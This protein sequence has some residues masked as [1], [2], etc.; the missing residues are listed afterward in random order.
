M[1]FSYKSGVTILVLS[2]LVLFIVMDWYVVHREDSLV[3]RNRRKEEEEWNIK[4]RQYEAE[5]ARHTSQL[6]QL[7]E[8]KANVEKIALQKQVLVTSLAAEVESKKKGIEKLDD[9]I[10]QL[11]KTKQTIQEQIWSSQTTLKNNNEQISTLAQRLKSLQVETQAVTKKSI[12]EQVQ[13]QTQ[14]VQQTISELTSKK[15]REISELA[16]L[17][18]TKATLIQ[19]IRLLEQTQLTLSQRVEKIQN[20]LKSLI[21]SFE[22]SQTPEAY[23]GQLQEA[24]DTLTQR[25][26]ELETSV[27][28]LLNVVES[29]DPTKDKKSRTDEEC[30]DASLVSELQQKKREQEEEKRWKPFY[31]DKV[32]T[33]TVHVIPHTHWDREWY[34]SF[35][36]FR[37]RLVNLV[38]DVLQFMSADDAYNHF[39]MDGQ[40]APIDDFLEVRPS[41]SS[42]IGL[43]NRQGRFSLGPW[44]VQPDEFLVSAESM[45]RNL[46]LGIRRAKEVGGNPLL[47]GYLPDSFGHISQ[48][49]QIFRG[50]EIDTTCIARGVSHYDSQHFEQ[51]WRSP[52][53]SQV[54]VIYISNWYC[55]GIDETDALGAD[56]VAHSNTPAVFRKKNRGDKEQIKSKKF[57]LNEWL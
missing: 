56:K 15:N 14:A 19:D 6:V 33:Y 9:E 23:L 34:L 31:T 16:E 7:Q 18:S 22:P 37:Y 54:F 55:N 52:D 12:D 41:K 30:A 4:T 57:S 35:E 45:V 40:M 1:G 13:L 43:R 26:K 29:K 49:P 42:E 21:P 38:D 51:F 44:Y 11:Q 32:A 47:L 20:A 28:A 25:K 27:T 10:E 50:F 53:G 24:F 36:N 17:E 3:Q 8:E 39:H 2:C 48:L 46:M 5:R